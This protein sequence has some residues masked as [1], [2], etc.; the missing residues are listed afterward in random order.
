MMNGCLAFCFYFHMLEKTQKLNLFF[1]FLLFFGLLVDVILQTLQDLG[2]LTR[3]HLF[4]SMSILGRKTDSPSI[5]YGVLFVCFF[6]SFL[7]SI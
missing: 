3:H 6:F 2:S 1:C 5:L 4:E 7:V